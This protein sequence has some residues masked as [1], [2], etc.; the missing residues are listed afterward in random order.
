MQTGV[1]QAG[2]GNLKPI[3]IKALEISHDRF[4]IYLLNGFASKPITLTI[5]LYPGEAFSIKI[6][7]GWFSR[8]SNK[9]S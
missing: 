4:P 2:E 6:R 3:L 7:Q 5:F 8:R 9:K 1:S